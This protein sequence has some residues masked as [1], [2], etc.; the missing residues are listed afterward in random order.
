M[1]LPSDSFNPEIVLRT[2]EEERCTVL[3]GVPTMF[4]AELEPPDLPFGLKSIPMP[5]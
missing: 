3:Y 5:S 2:L 1:V 4:A